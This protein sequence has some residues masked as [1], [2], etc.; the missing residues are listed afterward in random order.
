MNLNLKLLGIGG[1]LM[2]TIGRIMLSI[3]FDALYPQQP[4][5]FAHWLM[6]VGAIL[7]LSFSFVFPK[8]LIH[9]V[10]TVLT[11]LGVVAHIG[12]CTI[13]FILWSFGE[14]LTS[15]NELIGHLVHIPSVWYPFM[16]V[17]PAMLYAGLATHAWKF[18]FSHSISAIMTIGGSL[19]IG[20]G[21]M[22][23]NDKVFVVVGYM[24]FSIGLV[25]LVYRKTK[26]NDPMTNFQKKRKS[27]YIIGFVLL[28]PMGYFIFNSV[29]NRIEEKKHRA[30]VES[31][32]HSAS[33]NVH[34]LADTIE[35][36]YL[37][38]KRT[39]AIY[40]PENYEIDSMDYSVIYFLDG[41]SLFD[42]KNTRRNGMGS[43]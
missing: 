35:I 32:T 24:V 43:R 8:S 25:F 15:R 19:M 3:G 1:L 33:S 13:D 26:A 27:G 11:V 40:L 6:L 21:Q 39:L 18:I 42:Q 5:D 38:E 37:N 28:I 29:S 17:G 41:E 36:D 12:M 34:I 23:W 9:T 31:L 30:W 20:L 7:T 10:A 16:I 2:L 14:D 22:V 4:I